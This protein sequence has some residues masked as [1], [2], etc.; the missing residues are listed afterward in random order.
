MEPQDAVDVLEGIITK[1]RESIEEDRGEIKLFDELSTAFL[2]LKGMRVR[3]AAPSHPAYVNAA[4]RILGERIRNESDEVREKQQLIQLAQELLGLFKEE[5]AAQ[6]LVAESVSA[7]KSAL[8]IVSWASVRE[9]LMMP[10]EH[11]VGRWFRQA[12][13]EVS[14][15]YLDTRLKEL[16][17]VKN[18]S[19]TIGLDDAEVEWFEARARR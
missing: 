10:G 3:I 8:P 9:G 1:L 13:Y 15:Y 17:S 16:R 19:R 5:L 2:S 7:R 18:P 11:L 14:D 6:R 4:Y 12:D